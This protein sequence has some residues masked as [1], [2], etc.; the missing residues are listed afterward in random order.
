[1]SDV[2][3]FMLRIAIAL[4]VWILLPQVVLAE[5]RVALVI[6]NSAYKHTAQLANPVNDAT[7]MAA[8]L[9]KRGFEVIQGF[10]LD[11]SAFD[12]KVRDFANALTGA[13][14]GLFF[15]AGHGLQLGG[16]NYLAPIDAELTGAAALDFEM[17]R[18]DVV[19]RAMEQ[20]ASTNII[21]LDACRDNPLAR[22][23]ARS[24]GTRSAQ[25]GRGLAPAESGIGTLISFSTQPGNTALDGVG[26]NSPFSQALARYVS[27][28]DDD[29]SAI[30]IAVRNDVRK[31]TQN[32]QVPWEH[33][34]LTG[35]FYFGSGEDPSVERKAETIAWITA[36]KSGNAAAFRNYLV[37]YP[38]GRHADIA[39]R[40]F[41]EAKK[42]ADA[43]AVGAK[44]YATV[45]ESLKDK[46]ID[47]AI[48]PT[49]LGLSVGEVFNRNRS[50]RALAVCLDWDK[51]TPFMP[52]PGSV[53][54][55]RAGQDADAVVVRRLLN[56]CTSHHAH[57]G[58]CVCTPVEF[59][60]RIVIE[61]PKKWAQRFIVEP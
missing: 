27:T 58:G 54:F 59:K 60:E 57:N 47:V 7:D 21:F 11:K 52:F 28:S 55:A 20:Q 4:L 38:N 29:L 24:M 12:R 19:L 41:V 51:S 53:E 34:A 32:Q 16:T 35:R 10:D 26:R 39:R 2:V 42:F 33:S 43:A 45:I 46:I 9:K 50:N 48:D 8:V 5:K 6:G 13:N 3:T 22:N 15:Y 31:A 40:Q 37:Q 49:M 36:Q 17:V 14:A 23:L 25:I 1:M 30:L 56:A 61:V 44:L 18:L